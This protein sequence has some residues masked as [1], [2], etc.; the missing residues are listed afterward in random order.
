MHTYQHVFAR[1]DCKEIEKLKSHY[2][3]KRKVGVQSIEVTDRFKCA[4]D[5]F[6]YEA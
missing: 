4:T 2:T 3:S 6:E 1:A 5:S